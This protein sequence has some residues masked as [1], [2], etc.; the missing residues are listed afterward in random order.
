[1][2][3]LD[4]INE[5]SINKKTIHIGIFDTPEEA[6]KAYC[7]AADKYHKEFANHG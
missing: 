1:L 4:E 3:I 7:R 5:S 6:H 2:G